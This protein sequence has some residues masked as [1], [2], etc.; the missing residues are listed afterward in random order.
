M[1]QTGEHHLHPFFDHFG[2]SSTL[3]LGTGRHNIDP[4]AFDRVGM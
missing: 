1:R 4:F 2:P 3:V